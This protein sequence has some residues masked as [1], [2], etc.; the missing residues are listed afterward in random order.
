MECLRPHQLELIV[1]IFPLRPFREYTNSSRR[2]SQKFPVTGKRLMGNVRIGH[3]QD[4][5]RQ[6]QDIKQ[7]P[8]KKVCYSSN[9]ARSTNFYLRRISLCHW[10]S[11]IARMASPHSRSALPAAAQDL[12]YYQPEI[13][14]ANRS[15][16]RI[17]G[18]KAF[19]AI[20]TCIVGSGNRVKAKNHQVARLSLHSSYPSI[21]RRG[22]RHQA[23]A[24]SH[25][26][27][28]FKIPKAS[29]GFAETHTT[30]PSWIDC[31]IP[32]KRV[33][34]RSRLTRREKANVPRRHNC[35]R[36]RGARLALTFR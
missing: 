29:G 23:S 16:V 4:R 7:V 22:T 17:G 1:P 36:D 30:N 3:P 33:Q 2:N 26:R 10:Q 15:R 12:L 21:P 31:K 14:S 5:Q 34:G 6:Y 24:I 32:S 8:A 19:P 9:T 20:C 35:H 28:A 11:N 27:N 25:N 13:D 18:V